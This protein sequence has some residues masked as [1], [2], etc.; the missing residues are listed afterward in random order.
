MIYEFFEKNYLKV[1]NKIIR[2]SD[3]QMRIF[4][5][6]LKSEKPILAEKLVSI[7]QNERKTIT[8]ARIRT[9]VNGIKNRFDE[10][11]IESPIR[12]IRGEGYFI[13]N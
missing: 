13:I 4:V 12:N 10:A 5:T 3:I 11:G 7:C 2:L 6:I 8:A 1:E 9:A